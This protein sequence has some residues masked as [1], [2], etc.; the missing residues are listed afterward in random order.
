M[1]LEHNASDV[2]L[3][4]HHSIWAL[5]NG[6]PSR[7][8]RLVVVVNPVGG[9]RRALATYKN[10]VAPLL[11][12]AAITT[13][14]TVTEYQGHGREVGE[15]VGE[16]VDG[17]VAV[18]GDGL[19]NEV[20]LGLLLRSCRLHHH[21]P[22]DHTRPLPSTK[23]RL[24]IIP[25][26]STDAT[27]HGTHGTS[28]V[29]TAA[30]HIIMGDSRSV[31]LAAVYSG[32]KLQSVAT[33]MVSYGYFGDLL[34]T[35]ERWRCLGPTRY[36]V[37]GLVQFFRNRS[38]EGSLKV[39]TPATPLSHTYDIDK[40]NHDCGVCDNAA[41][42]TSKPGEWLQFNGRW[43]IVTSAV[44]SCACR[45]TPHGISPTAHLG[46]GCTDLIL[47]S[48]GSRWRVL[49]YLLRTAYTGDAARLNHVNMHRVQ[50]V[51]FTPKV[52]KPKSS[53]NCD[54]EQLLEPTLRL[55]VHCQRL[56][57]FSRGV[58]SAGDSY[59]KTTTSPSASCKNASSV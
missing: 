56:R 20:V 25:G 5:L 3:A 21:D 55:K 52:N 49:T 58:E 17:V 19:V 18:G 44:M 40:C 2:I 27:C 38:Y 26:G 45:L 14:L 8:R 15:G 4:W 7:P 11:H 51:H 43:S 10:K 30:L 16:G 59:T 42:S 37:A 12:R 50:E 35:S 54:G 9:R 23:L 6:L 34:R 22:H 33:T 1:V 47:V 53:W 24:G 36:L 28:D 13:S 46:D 31:D 29:I 32:D 41:L 57:L 48:G 39:L